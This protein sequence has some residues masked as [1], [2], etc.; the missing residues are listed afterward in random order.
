M[1][2]TAEV[3]EEALAT[4]TPGAAEP[5]RNGGLSIPL[6]LESFLWKLKGCI[7]GLVDVYCH[8]TKIEPL[9]A[10]DMVARKADSLRRKGQY[11]K[12][13]DQYQRLIE[14]GKEEAELYYHLG[15]CCER[16]AMD[17][18]AEA[19]YKKAI[20]MDRKLTDANYRLGLLAIRNDDAKTAV[21]YLSAVA[22]KDEESFDVL[23]NLGVAFDKA[24][25]YEK[26][27]VALTKA[28]DIEPHYAKG[29][30]RLGY[31]YDAMGKHKEST[32]CFKKAMELEEV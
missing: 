4:Q 24:K 17:E 11:G 23:Y 28:I 25:A 26:A 20:Q 21:K 13:I 8:L 30:K 31:V 6:R 14:M 12:A 5:S 18:E 15:I 16:E 10:R 1:D 7:D 9:E 22:S 29:H 2:E 3:K 32:E 19:A 27:V